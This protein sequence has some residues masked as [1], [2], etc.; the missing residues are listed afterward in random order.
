LE[1]DGVEYFW[2]ASP[3]K[4]RVDGGALYDVELLSVCRVAN[5]GG[6]A[7]SFPGGT[8]VNETHAVALVRL[9]QVRGVPIT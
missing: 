6:V 4:E 9:C 5:T 8:V 7:T 1:V 3:S 2:S